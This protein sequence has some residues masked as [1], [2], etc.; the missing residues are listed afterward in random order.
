MA[1]RPVTHALDPLTRR[2]W[3][4][5]GRPVDLST[6][7]FAFL[8]APHNGRLEV[9]D[10]W[11]HRYEK[12]G[13]VDPPSPNAG[14]FD[15]M[16]VLDGP[17]FRAADLHPM[18]RDFYEHTGSWRMEVW[19]QWNPLF[20]PGGMA[21]AALF[22]RRVEQLALPTEPLSVSRGMSSEVRVVTDDSGHRE[23]AAWLRRLRLDGSAVYSGFYRW[24]VLPG[25]PQPHVAVAF[26]LELGNVHVFL[27]PRAEVDGA[28][29][30]TSRSRRFGEDGAYVSVLFGEE[31]HSAQ[32]PLRESFRVYVDDE[33]VL[34]TDHELRVGRFRALRLHYRL[35]RH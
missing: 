13:E 11:L 15:D 10:A 22:G 3:R 31:W 16:S 30:L 26:P 32:P 19:S 34:R 18:V 35:E 25:Q 21:V 17:D 8:A 12:R 4:A 2:W 1:R 24:A 20:A 23:G 33:G 6:P 5:V 27:T 29:T 9:G 14:L 28:L 7:D